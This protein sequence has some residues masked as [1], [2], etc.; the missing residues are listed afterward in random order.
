MD[1]P[2]DDLSWC[3]V[4]EKDCSSCGAF[5]LESRQCATRISAATRRQ[6]EIQ[7]ANLFRVEDPTTAI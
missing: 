1:F 4:E 3:K 5:V 6:R 7:L 2:F